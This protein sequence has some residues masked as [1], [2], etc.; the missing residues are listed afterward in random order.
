[1]PYLVGEVVAT[2]YVEGVVPIMAIRDGVVE[3]PVDYKLV[4]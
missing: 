1:M 4:R 3:I 2:H